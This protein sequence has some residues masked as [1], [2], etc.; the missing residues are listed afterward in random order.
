MPWMSAWIETQRKLLEQATGTGGEADEALRRLSG[1]GGDY[2]GVAGAWWRLFANAAAAPAVAQI[3]TP[4]DL[5]PLRALFLERYRQL[6]T[7]E[8]A[9]AAALR[10]PL[11]EGAAETMRWQAANQRFGQQLAAI[12]GDAFQR[13]AAALAADDATR[14][15][16][17]SLRELHELWIECGEAAYAAGAHGD[18]FADAQAE[19][20]A[21]LVE[22]RGLQLRARA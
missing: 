22:L 5:E 14:P 2:V 8:F 20:L 6:F 21:A 12:A 10:D 9:L 1:F 3:L 4:A 16:I 13:L 18:A 17:T 19:L 15:P 7:P 11:P